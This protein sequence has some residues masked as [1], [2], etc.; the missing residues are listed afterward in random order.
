MASKVRTKL[1]KQGKTPLSESANMPIREERKRSMLAEDAT[2]IDRR[3]QTAFYATGEER[4]VAL[5]GMNARLQV[6]EQAL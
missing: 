1:P 6:R 4:G 2:G 3:T 5:A